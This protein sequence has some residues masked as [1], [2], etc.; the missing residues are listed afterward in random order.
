MPGHHQRTRARLP[1]MLPLPLPPLP[2]T[3]AALVPTA[4]LLLLRLLHLGSP[5]AWLRHHVPCRRELSSGTGCGPGHSLTA[6]D[7]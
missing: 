3:E 6:A 1:W 4:V 7:A 2:P 5:L